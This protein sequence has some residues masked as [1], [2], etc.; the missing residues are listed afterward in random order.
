MD[1][2]SVGRRAL[3]LAIDALVALV[4]WVPFATFE[5]GAGALRLSWFGWRAVVP[6]IITLAYFTLLP[7]FAGVTVGMLAMRFR[8]HVERVATHPSPVASAP[9]PPPPAAHPSPL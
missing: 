8:T 7:L 2:V 5:S 4:W 3:A 9:L 1:Y 6:V